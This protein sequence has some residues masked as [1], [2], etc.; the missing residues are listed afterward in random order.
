M[1][2]LNQ[3]ST[4]GFAPSEYDKHVKFLNDFL[5]ELRLRN[6]FHVSMDDEISRGMVEDAPPRRMIDEFIDIHCGPEAVQIPNV[7]VPWYHFHK[8]WERVGLSIRN[9]IDGIDLQNG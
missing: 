1:S 3:Q 2:E 5:L 9:A 6:L 4:A 8:A 7:T